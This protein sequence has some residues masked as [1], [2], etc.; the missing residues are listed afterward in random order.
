MCIWKT[1]GFIFFFWFFKTQFLCIA[2]ADLELA[3]YIRLALN[4]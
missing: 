3:L 2:L 1:M 4:L